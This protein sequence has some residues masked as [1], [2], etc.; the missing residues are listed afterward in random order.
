VVSGRVVVFD[1]SPTSAHPDPRSI[2]NGVAPKANGMKLISGLPFEAAVLLFNGLVIERVDD[3][4]AMARPVF[5]P[6]ASSIA[7]AERHAG[8]PDCGMRTGRN[9]IAYRAT[10]PG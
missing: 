6:M 3:P 1:R 8:S 2:L 10:Y 4:R 5:E 9:G 7:F